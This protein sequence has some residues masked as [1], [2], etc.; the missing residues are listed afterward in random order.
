MRSLGKT[1]GAVLAG[2]A[3]LAFVGTGAAQ[4]QGMESMGGG[5]TPAAQAQSGTAADEQLR[6]LREE[7]KA[8]RMELADLKAGRAGQMPMGP[9]MMGGM[10]QMPMGPGMMGGQMGQMMP[11]M[12]QPMMQ[13]MQGCAQ[14]MGMMGQMGD[15]GRT[16]PQ[17][18]AQSPK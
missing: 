4:M 6:Q 1:T 11:Q 18:K 5:K 17:S 16:T 8:L 10:G 9:G 12:M 15:M 7:I 3:L 14:M 13:M 2:V